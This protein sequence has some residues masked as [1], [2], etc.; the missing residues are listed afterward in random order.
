A[1]GEKQ[2]SFIGGLVG[3]LIGSLLGVGSIILFGQLGYVSALSGII[4][5][6]CSLKGYEFL[7]GKLTGKG[8]IGT[9]IVMV[10][11]VYVGTRLDWSI[12]IASVV[13]EVDFLTA[14]RV[15][16]ELLRKGFV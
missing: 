14:F 13:A 3:G 6:V 16:P 8:I 9:S 5:A 7:G 2:E 4:M 15:F 11:M 1:E 12:S 10:I